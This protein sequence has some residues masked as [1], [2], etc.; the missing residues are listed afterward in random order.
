MRIKTLKVKSKTEN[1]SVVRDFISSAAAEINIPKDVAENIIL[2]VDEACTNIIKHAYKYSP[3]GEIIVKV[4][5]SLSKFVVSIID[6]GLSFEPDSIPEPDLQKYYR[7]RRVGGLGV[8]LMK[9]LMD[10]VKYVSKPGKYNEVLLSKNLKVTQQN[11][12]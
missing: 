12:G 9:T 7:Q 11:A 3:D 8:Y 2:A 5:P 4:K 10:E 1:L 6:N